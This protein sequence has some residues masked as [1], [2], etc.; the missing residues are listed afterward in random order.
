[1]SRPGVLHV[2][3]RRHDDD[4][5]AYA[6]TGTLRVADRDTAALC[7]ACGRPLTE[8][9]GPRTAARPRMHLHCCGTTTSRSGS[10]SLTS[11]P[12][13]A[14]V[15]ARR[16]GCAKL[17]GIPRRAGRTAA[18]PRVG[19]GDSTGAQCVPMDTPHVCN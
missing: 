6:P 15:K 2:P 10:R 18:R 13:P 9:T 14:S 19:T 8:I 1:M 11:P 12:R 3:R 4:S 5:L 7:H 17:H 16:G